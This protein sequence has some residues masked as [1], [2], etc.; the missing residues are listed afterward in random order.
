MTGKTFI[1]KLHDGAPVF[2]SAITQPCPLWTH[3]AKEIGLDFVFI[4]NEHRPFS[5]QDV[6]NLCQIYAAQEIVPIVRIPSP[7]ASLACMALDSGAWGIVAPYVENITEIEEI[8]GAVKYAP[9]KGDILKKG[10]KTGIWQ[11][12]TLEFLNH[13]NS[14]RSVIINIES[15][16]ALEKLDQLAAVPGLDAL[17]IGPHDLTINSG[18]PQDYEQPDFIQDVEEI[19]RIGRKHHL[20]VGIHAWWGTLPVKSWMEKGMNLILYSSDYMAARQKLGED[21]K[22]LRYGN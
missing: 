18:C 2:G 3:I 15:Q 19:I 16:P 6:A 11:P 13:Q 17:L 14:H 12:K 22:K 1:Q 21:F 4:D 8:V 10:L 20:G 9:L 5:R 7:D